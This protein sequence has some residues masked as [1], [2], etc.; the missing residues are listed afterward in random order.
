MNGKQLGSRGILIEE[1]DKP[2]LETPRLSVQL[3]GNQPVVLRRLGLVEGLGTPPAT[4]L[5]QTPGLLLR[6][7]DL[8][9]AGLISF[10]RKTFQVRLGDHILPIPVERVTAA[11]LNPVQKNGE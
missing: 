2:L 10:D 7:G 6:N 5:G 4:A 8:L 11:G 9:E 1:D 3:L